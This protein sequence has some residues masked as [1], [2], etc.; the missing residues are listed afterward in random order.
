MLLMISGTML[1]ITMILLYL[2]WDAQAAHANQ[3][4][5]LYSKHNKKM[6]TPIEELAEKKKQLEIIQQ[7]TANR[8]P[9]M[10]ILDQISTFP[11][12]GSTLNGG[13]LVITDF[14]YTT[15]EEVKI[16]GMAMNFEDMQNFADFLE[17]MTYTDPNGDVH[18]IFKEM[19]LPQPTPR[20]LSANRGTVYQFEI[21]GTLNYFEETEED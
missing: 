12:I 20:P 9:A 4:S 7:I 17:R 8:T 2:A 21:T 16:G 6:E 11:G 10:H 13:I 18:A 14:K 19:T 5:E 1:I 15:R 3:L